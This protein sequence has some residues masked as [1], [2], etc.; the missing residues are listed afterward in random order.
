MSLEFLFDHE[1]S[2][3]IKKVLGSCGVGSKIGGCP[4]CRVHGTVVYHHSTNC[5]Y[6]SAVR[7][8][9]PDDP[10]REEFREEF[11]KNRD[12]KAVADAQEPTLMTTEEA[13]LAA[14]RIQEKISSQK[15]EYYSFV[16]PFHSYFGTDV[17]N[18][19]AF[20]PCHAIGK[21][22]EHLLCLIFTTAKSQMTF[23]EAQK[24]YE[25]GEL[26]RWDDGFP[27]RA[28]PSSRNLLHE[29]LQVLPKPKGWSRIHH[30]VN[31]TTTSKVIVTFFSC[32][33]TSMIRVCI[34]CNSTKIHRLY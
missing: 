32:Q 17:V 14:E 21:T 9:P 19:T 5:Y 13:I 4:W 6:F 11:D 1:D 10:L 25:M 16:S 2:Q 27:F 24:A 34:L 23:S 28:S 3:G 15:D 31:K 29:L 26:G 12:V 7:C 33:C 30:L 8:L 18:N 20:D 22:I